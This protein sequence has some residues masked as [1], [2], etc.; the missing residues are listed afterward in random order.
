MTDPNQGE[1]IDSW[2]GIAEYL[3][4]G[5]RTVQRWEREE[6]LPV[7]RLQHEKLGSIYAYRQELDTWWNQRRSSLDNEPAGTDSH[8]VSIAVLPFADLSRE[9]DQ[10]YFCDGVAEEIILALSRIRGLRMASRGS[11][12]RFRGKSADVCAVGR[13]LKVGTILEGGVRKQQDSLRITVELVDVASGYHLWSE[14]YDRTMG[15]VFAIQ[16]EIARSVA[17]A[18]AVT[19]TP[20]ESAALARVPTRDPQA[21]DLYLRGRAYYFRYGP[22]DMDYAIQLFLEATARDQ[23]FAPA[24]AGL[25]DCWSYLYLYSERNDLLREQAEWASQKALEIDP[26]S[27]QACASLALARS[28]RGDEGAEA[29]FERAV[30]LDPNLF[31]AWYFRARHAFARGEREKAL[32]Y[33]REA[34]RVHPEDYQS[35]L[36]MAQTLDDLGQQQQALEAR[37]SGIALAEDHLRIYPDDVRAVYCAANGMA[38]LGET[39]RARELCARALAIRPSDG[40]VLYNVGCVYSLLGCREE[41]LAALEKAVEC[42]LRET[43]W[44]EHDSN[45]DPLRSDPRFQQL[46]ARL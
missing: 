9:Q 44:Y 33:Y 46:L 42:G 30:Q 23:T 26:D 21:H 4:R 22:Q 19:L 13:Q 36:L 40:M 2:K 3:H 37:R 45:L 14:A 16:E 20:T 41:A 24:W 27:A 7:H 25:A 35:P 12:F 34:I 8:G 17:Q 28:L 5:T 1:R 43:G 31:E 10:E 32:R 18:L 38:A 15:D 11:S 6:G 39:S 29:A